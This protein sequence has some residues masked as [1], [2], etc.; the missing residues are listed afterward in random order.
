MADRLLD[1]RF[2]LLI[3]FLWTFSGVL[4]PFAAAF[5]LGYLLDPVA[6]RLERLG[7]N[8]LG[9]TLIILATFIL[10][11]ALIITLLV[12]VL[13]HQLSGLIQ[14]FPTYVTKLQELIV[15]QS[16]YFTQGYGGTLLQKLGLSGTTAAGEAA[17]RRAISCR[18][19]RPGQA[20]F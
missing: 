13:G 3:L 4:L 17:R 6:D 8:R 20:L 10:I 9:A 19:R 14:S 12:P 2:A 15:Q 11:L 5:C 18:R 7:L 1:R 16:E